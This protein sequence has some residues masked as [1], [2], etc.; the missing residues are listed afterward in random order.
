[1]NGCK[2]LA[3]AAEEMVESGSMEAS[4]SLAMLSFI[5]WLCGLSPV[6]KNP[7]LEAGQTCS[8]RLVHYSLAS[9]NVAFYNTYFD[10]KDVF[11]VMIT[12][13]FL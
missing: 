11:L 2:S 10:G 1:M 3:Q 6:E 12:S 8:F 4:R 5:R 7:D 13:I 9:P